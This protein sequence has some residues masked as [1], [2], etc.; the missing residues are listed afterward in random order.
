MCLI[1]TV[2]FSNSQFA[3]QVHSSFPTCRFGGYHDVQSLFSSYN[4]DLNVQ[5]Y[6][7]FCFT[8]TFLFV[9]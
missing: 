8:R 5:D 3:L 2:W 7:H 1:E 9:C 4:I 6:E